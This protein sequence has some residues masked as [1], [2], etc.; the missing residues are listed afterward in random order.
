MEA[1]RFNLKA[2]IKHSPVDDLLSTAVPGRGRLW[3][4]L[5]I[6]MHKY[7]QNKTR[8]KSVNPKTGRN[9]FDC[10]VL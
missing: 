3:C 6:F 10:S 5:R 1:D 4:D 2:K 7:I 9:Y 8:T